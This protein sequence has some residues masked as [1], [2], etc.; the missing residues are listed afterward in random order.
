MSASCPGWLQT[1]IRSHEHIQEVLWVLNKRE[2]KRQRARTA[3]RPKF[4]G[5]IARRRNPAAPSVADAVRFIA[6]T[7][8]HASQDAIPEYSISVSLRPENFAANRYPDIHPFD[9]TRVI[10]DGPIIERR[11]RE[12][13]RYINASWVRER[14]G[15]NWWIASQAPLP[16]T[17]HTFLSI[18]LQTD[19][20]PPKSLCIDNADLGRV[21][22][23]VQL[24][25][26]QEDGRIKAHSY[27]PDE[28]GQTDIVLPSSSDGPITPLKITLVD[29]DIIENARCIR[30]LLHVSYYDPRQSRTDGRSDDGVIFQHLLYTAWPDHGVPSPGDKASLLR[31]I[32][33]VGRAN[34]DRSF[35]PPDNHPDP[36]IIVGCSA[37]IGRTGAFITL[38]SLLRAYGLMDLEGV[39]PGQ[40][41]SR[42][43]FTPLPLPPSPLGPLPPEWDD[44]E[45]AQEIDSLR[46]QRPG[47]VQ[48]SDQVLLVYELLQDAFTG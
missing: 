1:A 32:R 20:R 3:S 15:G 46:E 28:I 2:R 37:G 33:L 13:G 23:V 12:E 34:R 35:Q 26:S 25:L 39:R 21:R 14:Y 5:P 11:P 22:T 45:V 10:V 47:M 44:D 8:A 40:V 6:Q 16:T 4:T 17:A 43:A 27:F 30:S 19:I 48:R 29:R 36:P 18:L 9:R 24:T 31:F 41:V 38:S 42:H 7:E